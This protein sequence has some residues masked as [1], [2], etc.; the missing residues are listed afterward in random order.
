[1]RVSADVIRLLRALF[2][3]ADWPR[4]DEALASAIRPHGLGPFAYAE[5]VRQGAPAA[6]LRR[7]WVSNATSVR[8]VPD[9]GDID[10]IRWKGIDYASSLYEDA[11]ERPMGDVDLLVREKDF[12]PARERLRLLGYEDA[13]VQVGVAAHPQHY[14]AQL[15]CEGHHVD[16]H[17]SVR[18]AMR[19]SVDYD[20]V[21]ARSQ[22]G[23]LDP[24]DRI[25]FHTAH[26]AAHEM[27]VPLIALVDLEKMIAATPL[28]AALFERAREHGLLRPL[29]AALETRA[30]LFGWPFRRSLQ[31]G[32]HAIVKGARVPRALQLARKAALLDSP[33]N[34]AR[35][36]LYALRAAS[37]KKP[38]ASGKTT[39]SA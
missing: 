21:F 6:I 33:R 28:S 30:E 38:T 10:V 26:M 31:P 4:V 18:Q 16:L 22:S 36:V 37:E 1:M 23:R 7:D 11:A 32:I 8:K 39:S 9:L 5:S 2:Q 25:I 34:A 12:A 17:R 27:M 20:G 3:R 15:V 24:F 14:A 29:H 35:F 13:L 19:A